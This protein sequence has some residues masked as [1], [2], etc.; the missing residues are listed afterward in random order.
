MDYYEY[1]DNYIMNYSSDDPIIKRKIY[2]NLAIANKKMHRKIQ[3]NAF[4]EKAKDYVINSSSEWRYY[5]LKGAQGVFHKAMPLLKYEKVLDFEPWFIV[6]A[7][8]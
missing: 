6:Y 3:A 4:L 5:N 7:H 2:L 1:L 8:D